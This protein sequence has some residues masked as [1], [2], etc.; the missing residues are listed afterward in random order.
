MTM[1]P[2]PFAAG[3]EPAGPALEVELALASSDATTTPFIYGLGA[4]GTK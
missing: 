3:A 1:I 4:A 2:L